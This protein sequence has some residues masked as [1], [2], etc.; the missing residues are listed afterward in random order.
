[1]P[2]DINFHRIEEN[3]LSNSLYLPSQIL[4]IHSKTPKNSKGEVPMML[5]FFTKI[6]INIDRGLFAKVKLEG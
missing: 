4:K 2:P 5:T 6:N 3:F 1:M